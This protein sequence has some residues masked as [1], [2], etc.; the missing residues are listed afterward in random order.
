LYIKY[1]HPEVEEELDVIYIEK[2]SELEEI[3]KSRK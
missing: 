3:L 2:L 1:L